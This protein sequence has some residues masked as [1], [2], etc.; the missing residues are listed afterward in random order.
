MPPSTVP[1]A[2]VRLDRSELAVKLRRLKLGVPAKS[3]SRQI[4]TGEEKALLE[5]RPDAGLASR[6]GIAV[7]AIKAA[8]LVLRILPVEAK[9]DW[10][11]FDAQKISDSQNDLFGRATGTEIECFASE[12]KH[13]L[14]LIPALFAAVGPSR[15]RVSAPAGPTR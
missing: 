11:A 3:R 9:Q 15:E 8:R 14:G 12:R 5:K 2:G 1:N 10:I 6:L 7:T 13:P 4:W